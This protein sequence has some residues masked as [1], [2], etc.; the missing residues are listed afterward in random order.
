MKAVF[1]FSILLALTGCTT[2]NTS[3]RVESL[4]NQMTLR[5]KIGQMNQ[6]SV[7]PE[8]TGPEGAQNDRY[9]QFENGEVGSAINLIGH[10]DI[11]KLQELVVEKSRLGIP[12]VFAHDVIHGYKTIFPIPLAESCSWDL[13][14]I[15][16]SARIAAKE[17]AADGQNWTFAPMVDISRDPRWGRVMEGAGEDPYWGSLVAAARVRGFQGEDL[18]DPLTLASC[19]KHFA[20]YGFAESGK[21]YNSALIGRNDLRNFVLPPFKSANNANTATFMNSFNDID[22]VPA[23]GNKWLVNDVLRKEW[24][25][26]GVLVSDWNSVGELVNHGV[27][28]DRAEASAL[29]LKA[30]TDM[31]MEGA[32]FI[33]NLEGLV[34]N[35]S[36]PE[37]L[38]DDAVRRILH[39]KQN[40]GLLDDPYRYLDSKREQEIVM[41]SQHLE[42]SLD[43]ARKSIVLLKNENALLPLKDVSSVAVIGP[44]AKDKDAPIGSWRA[45]GKSNS[46]VSFHEGLV[47]KLG[48]KVQIA[49]AEGCKLSIGPNNFL[50][51]LKIEQEDRSGFPG[52]LAVAKKSDVV[53]MVLGEPA[54]MS[55][56]ARSRSDIGLPGLQLELLQEVYKVNENIVLVLMNGRPL[57]IPWEEGNIPAILETWHLGS[58]AGDAIADVIVG[59]YNPSGKLTMSFPRSEGQIPIYY[60]YR[61]TGRP[62]N[63]N[64]LVF[65]QHHM[66][67]DRTPLFPF[68]HGLSYTTFDY[69]NLAVRTMDN[70][71]EI[72]VDVANTGE[73]QGEE[74]VMLY[75]RDKVASVS[76]PVLEL[77]GVRKILVD[78]GGQKTVK[79]ALTKEDLSFYNVL[80]EFVFEP[81]AFEISVGTSST[82]LLTET[83]QFN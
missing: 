27:V 71:L 8:L 72:T 63:D 26:D 73:R 28:K 54:F 36:L 43:M 7:G 52:A 79:F 19:A 10:K 64:D 3:N 74:V 41:H 40:L 33:D 34:L 81:G 13:Q 35:G 47:N 44:L 23:T 12:L 70:E 59:D 58:R 21:D 18:S 42:A 20:G 46:A 39:L 15:E 61:N 69:S 29:A 77:K 30:G 49:Y 38:I 53:F 76:R 31:D 48:N 17:A 11:R 67:V 51:K 4:L 82:D 55:G 66:D 50:N 32:N 80:E 2:S 1:G 62:E 5:E 14:A 16:K 60:N 25:F 45:Q 37:S 75:V 9:S 22:G 24:M 78:P 56:E 57:C 65:Y 6:Y 68:G 83:V